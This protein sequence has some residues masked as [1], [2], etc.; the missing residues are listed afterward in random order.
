MSERWREIVTDRVGRVVALLR[1]HGAMVWWVGLPTMR[2]PAYNAQIRE[3]NAFY[4]ARMQAL[5]VP[6]I[7]T[8]AP[9]AGPGGR[10]EPYLRKAGSGERFMARVNDGVHMTIPGYLLL[11]R[12]LSSD[13]ER[14]IAQARAHARRPAEGAPARRAG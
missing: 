3:M 2:D 4:A 7:D 1:E 10:Y 5:G 8:A 14:T 9:T 11:T 12:G 13:I 6:F